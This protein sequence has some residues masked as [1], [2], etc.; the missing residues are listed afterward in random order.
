MKKFKS[1]P[2]KTLQK[3]LFS[4]NY[5]QQENKFLKKF[6]RIPEKYLRTYENRFGLIDEEIQKSNL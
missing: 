5:S 4:P 2:T 1:R 6:L 3:M